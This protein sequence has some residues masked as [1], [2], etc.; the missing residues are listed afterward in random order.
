MLALLG[1]IEIR[2]HITGVHDRTLL[3]R[4]SY[5]ERLGYIPGEIAF[6]DD[7]T[8]TEFLRFCEKY[9]RAGDRAKEML[10]RFELVPKGKIKKM[11]KGMK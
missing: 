7:M 9:K 3:V 2:R 4:A 10:D 8:G 6:F 11:S 5:Q 1:L